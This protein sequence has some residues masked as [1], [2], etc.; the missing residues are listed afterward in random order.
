MCLVSCRFSVGAA[1]AISYLNL[2]AYT[3]YVIRKTL[4]IITT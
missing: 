2:S 4:I 1:Y 3:G